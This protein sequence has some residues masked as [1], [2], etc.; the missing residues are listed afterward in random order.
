MDTE[1][2]VFQD[3]VRR[4]LGAHAAGLWMPLDSAAQWQV[5]RHLH[6]HILRTPCSCWKNNCLQIFFWKNIQK[7]PTTCSPRSG[8]KWSRTHF[9]EVNCPMSGE[10]WSQ[11]L[12]QISTPVNRFIDRSICHGRYRRSITINLRE[13]TVDI[14]GRSRSTYRKLWSIVDNRWLG[15]IEMI[16]LSIWSTTGVKFLLK[17]YSGYPSDAEVTLFTLA[18]PGSSIRFN[19]HRPGSEFSFR[20]FLAQSLGS[21]YT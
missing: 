6:G 19:T 15:N 1:S 9:Q 21:C 4:L 3:F 17:S 5:H 13:N 12:I 20:F 18:N 10:E 16:L 7:W 11:H 14:D 8:E 2:R